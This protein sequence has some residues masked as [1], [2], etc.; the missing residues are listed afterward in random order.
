ML[1][2]SYADGCEEGKETETVAVLEIPPV[3]WQWHP[4]RE[5]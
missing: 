2:S 1:F 5:G 4:L 3:D